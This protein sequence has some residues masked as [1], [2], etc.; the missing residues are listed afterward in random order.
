M[1]KLICLICALVLCVGTAVSASAAV[2]FVPSITF[3]DGPGMDWATFDGEDVSDCLVI[4]TIKQANEKTTDITQDERDLLLDVYDKL[5]SGAMTLPIDES[6]TIRELLDVNYKYESCRQKP[7]THGD[8]LTELNTTDKTLTVQFNMG[9][10]ADTELIVMTYSEGKWEKIKSVVN[11]GDG[12]VTCEFEHL[13]PVVF[14]VKNSSTP[15]TPPQTGDTSDKYMPLWI[16]IMALSGVA[17]VTLVVVA[18]KKKE[19]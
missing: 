7:E 18:L 8:K 11:N 14:A 4:T 12:T 6:Y 13:C 5:N 16:G 10:T 19:H 1:K 3:K 15:S 17:L 9:V 2:S